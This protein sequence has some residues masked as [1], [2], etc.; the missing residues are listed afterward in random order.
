MHSCTNFSARRS[1]F[2]WWLKLDV[3]SITID[4]PA[5]GNIEFSHKSY[6][7]ALADSA[8]ANLVDD[9]LLTALVVIC[10]VYTCFL[11]DSDKLSMW[12]FPGG[13]S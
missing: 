12:P 9:L 11:K 6:N 3:T 5:A 2:I 7:P 10:I 13:F 8:G 4:G 1:L